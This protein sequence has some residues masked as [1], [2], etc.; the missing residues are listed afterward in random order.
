LITGG[1]VVLKS[2]LHGLVGLSK[3]KR[4]LGNPK[5]AR[6]HQEDFSGR[7]FAIVRVLMKVARCASPIKRFWKISGPMPQVLIA[8]VHSRL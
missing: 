5:M 7:A 6:M 4:S 2:L 3:G 8:A 1:P